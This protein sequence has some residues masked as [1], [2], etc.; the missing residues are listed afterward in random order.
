VVTLVMSWLGLAAACLRAA[1]PTYC[2]ADLAVHMLDGQWVSCCH[3]DRPTLPLTGVRPAREKQHY[4][5]RPYHHR[6]MCRAAP[7]ASK[8]ITGTSVGTC[9]S[10]Y[11]I[12][13][14]SNFISQVWRTMCITLGV[15]KHNFG[16][17]RYINCAGSGRIALSAVWRMCL[18]VIRLPPTCTCTA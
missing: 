17:L 15:G 16:L 6:R 4:L 1:P 12:G 8:A 13:Y 10:A 11:K 18:K 3:S 5:A 2:H 14:H 7:G 9:L